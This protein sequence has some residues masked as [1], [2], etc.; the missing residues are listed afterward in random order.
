MKTAYI[1]QVLHFLR[2]TIFHPQ[3]FS[4]RYEKLRLRKT[5]HLAKGRVLDVGCGRQLLR[6]HLDPHTT[7]ISLDFPETG[8]NLYDS[9][10][11]VFGDASTLPFMD[12]SFDTVVLLE[13]IE[14]IPNPLSAIKEALRVLKH[15]GLIIISSPFLYPIHDAPHDYFRWT[16][17]GMD[18]LLHVSNARISERQTMGNPIETGILLFNLSLAWSSLNSSWLNRIFFSMLSVILI[19][20]SNMFG[21]LLSFFIKFSSNNPFAI[22]YLFVAKESKR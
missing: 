13:I 22:G 1:R 7:Y 20:F 18:N 11:N 15:D 4:F 14:H 5:G 21:A 10:P 3:Y 19:P 8:K 9:R 6:Q 2:Y 16:I 17:H 12:A